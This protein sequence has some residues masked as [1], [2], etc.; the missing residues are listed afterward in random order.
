MR[1]DIR[2][3][4]Y[5]RVGRGTLFCCWNKAYLFAVCIPC[6]GKD[7]TCILAKLIKH[8]TYR[9][10]RVSW[11]KIIV[12]KE[13]CGKRVSCDK[14]D[15]YRGKRISWENLIF[16]S[17]EKSI[18]GKPRFLKG[19]VS[20]EKKGYEESSFYYAHPLKFT[21]FLF[22]WFFEDIFFL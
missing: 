3:K 10:K 8:D 16:L 7:T 18:E 15:M 11:K 17:C 2:T 21:K 1:K 22:L 9:R 20:L 14:K 4:G 13:Y 5:K 12:G 19:Y 6:K